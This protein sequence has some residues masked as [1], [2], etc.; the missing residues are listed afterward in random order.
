MK[1]NRRDF[2]KAATLGAA[3]TVPS[4]PALGDDKPLTATESARRN[5]IAVSTYSF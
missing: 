3:M 1:I 5:P 2:T 4:L